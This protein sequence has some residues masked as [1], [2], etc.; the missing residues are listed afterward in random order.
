LTGLNNTGEFKI[1]YQNDLNQTIAETGFDLNL[2]GV[3][4]TGD[5]DLG[6]LSL[7]IPDLNSTKKFVIQRGNET[8]AERVVTPHDPVVNV[9][10]PNG[11]EIYTQGE[12][13]TVTWQSLDS[14][15]GNLT[16][17]VLISENGGTEWLP[18]GLGISGNEFT[19]SANSEMISD[20]VRFRVI[21]S[22]GINTGEDVSDA[23]S[24]IAGSVDVDFFLHATGQTA[25]PTNLFLNS[26]APS[27][28]TA[29][30]KDSASIKFASGNQWKEI[31]TWS[32]S[33]PPSAVKLS[34][35]GNLTVW[36]GLKNSDDIGTRFDLRAEVYRDSEQVASGQ[37]YCITGVVR[38]PVNAKEV[39]VSFGAFP[40][41][42]FD[43]TDSLSIKILT[44]IGTN[45]DNTFCGGHSSAIGLRLY[46]DAV[47][48][49][50]MFDA[51]FD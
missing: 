25:N 5:L 29:K 33:S 18:L 49:P 16:H 38:N 17:A 12:N 48:R 41:E 10:S 14:D 3:G 51:T 43:G 26:T 47:D 40:P 28:T 20:E 37:T 4:E 35:L 42:E 2:D 7:R 19:F 24:S 15:G 39:N 27:A 22:D 1:L 31:G 44:R 45:Q 32:T 46:F 23:T 34:G 8:L 11:G 30:Y 13:I 50:S 21:A 36:L 6:I 9:T